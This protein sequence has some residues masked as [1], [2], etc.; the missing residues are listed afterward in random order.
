M[1]RLC[2][3]YVRQ[4]AHMELHVPLFSTALIWVVPLLKSHLCWNTVPASLDKLMQHSPHAKLYLQLRW[5]MGQ[6]AFLASHL[7]KQPRWK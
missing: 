4:T 5:Q 3:G 1:Y 6:V 7:S 2:N